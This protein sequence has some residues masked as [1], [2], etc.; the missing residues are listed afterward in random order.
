MTVPAWFEEQE[1][2]FNEAIDQILSGLTRYNAVMEAVEKKAAA[3]IELGLGGAAYDKALYVG[4]RGQQTGAR[5]YETAREGLGEDFTVMRNA[6]RSPNPN[7][8]TNPAPP[9]A[10][11]LVGKLKF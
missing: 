10:S 3:S 8:K 6:F 7:R 2:E 11:G 5:L 9:S 1:A 4:Q